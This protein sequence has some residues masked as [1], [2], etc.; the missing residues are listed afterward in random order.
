MLRSGAVSWFA[1][2]MAWL[3]T[4]LPGR[5]VVTIGL[6]MSGARHGR[7]HY[8]ARPRLGCAPHRGERPFP[9]GAAP[10]CLSDNDR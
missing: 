6:A 10:I 7:T 1:S 5:I 2:D 3:H 4:M 8:P 9:G